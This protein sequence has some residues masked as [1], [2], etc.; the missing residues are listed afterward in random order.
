[1]ETKLIKANNYEQAAKELETVSPGLSAKINEEIDEK[2][3]GHFTVALVRSTDNPVSKKYDHAVTVQQLNKRAFEKMEANLAVTGF[4]KMI[5]VHNPDPSHKRNTKTISLVPGSPA[6]AA[7][8]QPIETPAEMEARITAELSKKYEGFVPA[9]AANGAPM[10]VVGA[11]VHTPEEM[12]ARL[13]AEFELKFG[14]NTNPDV[15]K[16]EDFIAVTE[17]GATLKINLTHP[18]L[19]ID[20]ANDINTNITMIG[21]FNDETTVPNLKKFAA[22]NNIDLT[23]LTVKEKILDKLNAWKAENVKA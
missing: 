23:G 2:N 13:R 14:P 12:E 18:D 4:D 20:G 22:E 19:I 21:D 11:T 3:N 17:G 10:A 1:M 16:G 8:N 7:N 15:I 5:V 9:A 6:A